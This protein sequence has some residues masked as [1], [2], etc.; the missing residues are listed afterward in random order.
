MM[1]KKDVLAEVLDGLDTLRTV[2]LNPHNETAELRT[3]MRRLVMLLESLQSMPS[4]APTLY[5]QVLAMLSLLF[6]AEH[7][8]LLKRLSDGDAQHVDWQQFQAHVQER[9]SLLEVAQQDLP[10]VRKM[11]ARGCDLLGKPALEMDDLTQQCVAFERHIRCHLQDDEKV[12]DELK[13]LMAALQTSVQAMGGVLAEV[14]EDSPELLHTEKLLE[15]TLPDD[16]KQAQKLLQQARE[17]IL[18]AG[19][20]LNQASQSLKQT[21]TAHVQQMSVLSE[22]LLDAEAQARNDPLTGLANRRKLTEYLTESSEGLI[23]LM[24]DIDHFKAI[25]DRY[26]HDCG[27]EVLEKLAELLQT[28]VRDTDMVAR[29][30][31]E[32]FC[33]IVVGMVLEEA[34]QLAENIRQAVQLFDFSTKHG[35]IEVHISLGVAVCGETEKHKQWLK[36]AD[37][38][39]YVS[40]HEGRNRVTAA[41]A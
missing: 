17:G 4:I 37:E 34:M 9:K 29:L 16:P 15:Q 41:K 23:C 40:K 39:L 33:I 22:R 27:D 3:L 26:G 30:G 6:D 18:H 8:L 28:S 19:K 25:N 14:G 2:V 1:D 7:G 5:A 35:T 12:R 36:R 13:L 32:E 20:K 11:L 21:M 38:A 24:I 31:G 10:L